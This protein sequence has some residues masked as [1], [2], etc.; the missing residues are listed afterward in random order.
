[1]RILPYQKGTRSMIGGSKATNFLL[2]G[3]VASSTNAAMSSTATI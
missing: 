1:V 2:G 3:A